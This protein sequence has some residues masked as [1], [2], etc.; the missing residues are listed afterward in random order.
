MKE[1]LPDMFVSSKKLV[2]DFANIDG[3]TPDV[4]NIQKYFA[5]CQQTGKNPRLPENRQEFNDKALRASNMRYL[6]SGYSENRVA[7]LA[8]TQI[9]KEGR[10]YHL[11]VDIFSADLEPVLAPADGM[12]IRTGYEEGFGGYGFYS[13]FQ[14]DDGTIL[15]LGHLS[16]TEL[17]SE[18]YVKAGQVIARVGDFSNNEN[19]GWSRHLHIQL[20]NELPASETT[21]I[22]YS[23]LDN[24]EQNLKNFPNPLNLFPDWQLK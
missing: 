5:S 7:M 19:G 20:L 18:G 17:H 2:L 23:S 3:G 12:I 4:L 6:V 10:T 16:S 1:L 24:L 14:A 9:A 11:G 15:F 8:D 22:G 13:I 21:P